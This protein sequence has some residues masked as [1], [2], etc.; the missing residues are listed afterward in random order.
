MLERVQA[1][2]GQA[3][4]VAAGRVHAEDAALIAR[5]IAIGNVETRV[6]HACGGV[7][8]SGVEVRGQ[9]IS[10]HPEGSSGHGG[11]R[12]VNPPQIRWFQC[13]LV[14]C[15]TSVTFTCWVFGTPATPAGTKWM[16]TL[17]FTLAF[18]FRFLRS[19]FLI[20][21]LSF[22]AVLPSGFTASLN[23]DAAGM[24]KPCCLT[25][26]AVAFTSGGVLVWFR[27][28]CPGP[29]TF[30]LIVAVPFFFFLVTELTVIL[31]DGAA[32]SMNGRLAPATSVG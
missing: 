19:C 21:L 12:A 27:V 22:F 6:G 5:T 11:A 28:I 17:T 25:A 1:E 31:L 30:A 3:R 24:V 10:P 26:A 29:D 4:D 7:S 20:C 23:D 15:L 13:F 14:R 16:K 9:E 2:V 32:A 18:A 8:T